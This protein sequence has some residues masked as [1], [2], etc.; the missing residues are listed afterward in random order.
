VAAKP[1]RSQ[2]LLDANLLAERVSGGDVVQSAIS[3]RAGPIFLPAA[4]VARQEV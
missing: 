4:V 3:G 2:N 1:R